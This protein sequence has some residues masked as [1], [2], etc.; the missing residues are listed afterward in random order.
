MNGENLGGR[1][2]QD[3]KIS[4]S[5]SKRICMTTKSARGEE[6]RKYFVTCEK[7]LVIATKMITKELASLKQSFK[8]LVTENQEI[9]SKL[10]QI[11][12][13]GDLYLEQAELLKKHTKYLHDRIPV[14]EGGNALRPSQEAERAKALADAVK[15]LVNILNDRSCIENEYSYKSMIGQLLKETDKRCEYRF[16]DVKKDYKDA[17]G[18]DNDYALDMVAFSEDYYDSYMATIQIKLNRIREDDEYA[19]REGNKM[20]KVEQMFEEARIRQE[21]KEQKKEEMRQSMIKQNELYE[22]AY[23][24]EKDRPDFGTTFYDRVLISGH[25]SYVERQQRL[26]ENNGEDEKFDKTKLFKELGLID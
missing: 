9:K 1:P 25:E 6:A 2:T 10:K 20:E 8:A 23:Q 12:Q 11:D 13:K 14:W 5:F 21:E 7:G 17:Y 15:N 18:T 26:L 4:A 16:K 19:A 22:Q 3:Y 24:K